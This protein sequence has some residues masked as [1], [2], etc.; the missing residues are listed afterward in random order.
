M[1]Y[2][3]AVWDGRFQP[4]HR[5]HI[6]VIERIFTQFERDLTVM[7]IQS[8]EGSRDEYGDEV[9]RHHQLSR[10]PLTYW[11][12]VRLLEL[13]RARVPDGLKLRIQGIP[14]PDLYWDIAKPFYPPDR[15]LIVTGKDEY[16]QRKVHFWDRLGET[17]R[18]LDVSGIPK[19]SATEVKTAIHTGQGW[20][21]FLPD[22]TLEFFREIGGP[23]RFAEANI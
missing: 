20:E 5:G 21:R 18:L 17:T 4:L 13:S 12:R 14:R 23:R 15:F 3:N 8:S 22:G 2:Q 6:A 10:N 9:N 19:I 11:E 16:E 1:S 7:I